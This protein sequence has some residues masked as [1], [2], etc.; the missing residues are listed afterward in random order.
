MTDVIRALVVDSLH[1]KPLLRRRVQK[2]DAF[3]VGA[4]PDNRRVCGLEAYRD[5]S[6]I[7]GRGDT[8]SRALK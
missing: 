1:E 2:S 8:L 7:S 4:C 6:T 3:W 5:V